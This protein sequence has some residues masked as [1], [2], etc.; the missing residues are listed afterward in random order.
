MPDG[1]HSAETALEE[2]LQK[3]LGY[4]Q[5]A[6]DDREGLEMRGLALGLTVALSDPF[7]AV[8]HLERCHNDWEDERAKAR[9][10]RAEHCEARQRGK[11]GG[12]A[13]GPSCPDTHT[14]QH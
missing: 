2:A 14:G 5:G 9:E 12:Q 6:D 13:G 10:D 8:S 11:R 3:A 1:S 4:L 7:N